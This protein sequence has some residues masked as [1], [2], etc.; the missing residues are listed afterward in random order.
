MT[1]NSTADPKK[2][3]LL[4]PSSQRC[5]K[6][7]WQQAGDDVDTHSNG[8]LW[9]AHCGWSR[10][11]VLTLSN[12][13]S[14]PSCTQSCTCSLQEEGPSNL[15]RRRGMACS[16]LEAPPASQGKGHSS[17]CAYPKE[18]PCKEHV[19]FSSQTLT[20]VL[21]PLPIQL[22]AS[23]K[24]TLCIIYIPLFSFAALCFLQGK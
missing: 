19:C 7:G 17:V 14:L 12:C 24:A 4:L 11:A 18:C 20:S 15:P 16:V 3:G 21:N 10:P 2:T 22:P 13:S 23:G 5:S 6:Q 8:V 9:A 1:K